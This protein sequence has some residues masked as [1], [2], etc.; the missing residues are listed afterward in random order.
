MSV[1]NYAVNHLLVQHVVVCGHTNCCGIKAATQSSD[2]EIL[3][4]WLRNI[5]DDYC[6]HKT[7]LEA[8]ENEQNRYIRLAELNVQEQCVN[9]IKT[10][11]A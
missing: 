6:L 10:A 9:V 4:L 7:E 5:R 2:L 11:E 8:I 3:N 1:I